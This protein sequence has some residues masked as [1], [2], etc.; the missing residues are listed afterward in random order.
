MT[1]RDKPAPKIIRLRIFAS[2][3]SWPRLG[4][5][6]G[7]LLSSMMTD[8]LHP[9]IVKRQQRSALQIRREPP[10]PNPAHAEDCKP[11]HPV[12]LGTRPLIGRHRQPEDINHAHDDLNCRNDSQPERP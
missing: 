6:P 2:L 9:G 12:K 1:R 10:E 11:V 7:S 4:C 5:S 3:V 8:G